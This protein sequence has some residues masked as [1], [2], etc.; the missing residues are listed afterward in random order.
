ME[1]D[2]LVNKRKS[3]VDSS[4]DNNF[5]FDS[6]LAGIYTD[7]SH[8]IYEILQNAEDAK[9]TEVSF[10]L[11]RDRFDIIHNGV[12]F[13][14][15]DVDGLTG[16]G[17][18]SKTN[19]LNKIGKFGVG[20]K[21]VFA[22]TKNPIIHSGKYHFQVNDFVVPE[23]INMNFIDK[24]IIS[25]P[26]NHPKR[27]SDDLYLLIS[28]KLQ[29]IDPLTLLFLTNIKKI[30]WT[31]QEK[32]GSYSKISENIHK[33][34]NVSRITITSNIREQISISK[35][36]VL[37]RPV[38]LDNNK[39]FVEL[40]YKLSQDTKGKEHI[41]KTP[42][43]KL[44]VFFP[45]S[46]V[47]F[48][49]FI[50]QGPYKTIPN[51]EDIP[52]NDLQ[53][54]LLINETAKL[55][56]ESMLI[57]KKLNLFSISFIELLPIDTTHLNEYIYKKIF[58]T[59]KKEFN[60]SEKYIPI[61][62][63]SFAY[64]SET[65]LGRGK[66]LINLLDTDD[67]QYIY[68]KSHWINSNITIDNTRELRNYF[69]NQLEINEVDFRDFAIQI[70]RKYIYQKT[71]A[72]LLKFYR[73][74]LKQRTLWYNS[75][76][77]NSSIL[78]NKP[79][80]RLTDNSLIAPFNEKNQVQVFFPSKTYA[81]TT[82]KCNI[83][84]HIFVNDQQS[85]DFFHRLGVTMP[86]LLVNI[87]NSVL[88]KYTNSN[89]G[90][91]VDD[92]INDL[93]YIFSC[94]KQMDQ[95]KRKALQEETS[96]F[97]LIHSLRYP[98]KITQFYRASGTYL[99]TSQ[100]IEYF[101]GLTKVLFVSDVIYNNFS[102][103]ASELNEFLIFLG[104]NKLPKLVK[105]DVILT[106]KQK[107]ELRNTKM[108]KDSQSFEYQLEGLSNFFK[109]LTIKRSYLLWDLLLKILADFKHLD[110]TK[111]FFG[112]YSWFYRKKRY[113]SF[114]SKLLKQ[115][116]NTPWL[117]NKNNEF[118]KSTK[119]EIEDLNDA[120]NLS[121]KY[122]NILIK[123]LNFQLDEIRSFE[124]KHHCKVLSSEELSEYNEFLIWKQHHKLE[125]DIIDNINL[126]ITSPDQLESNAIII[127]PDKIKL[128][129]LKNQK[130][131][132]EKSNYIEKKSNKIERNLPQNH[133]D[134]KFIGDWGEQY[135]NKYLTNKYMH[136][137]SIS[138]I[139]QNT[140]GSKGSGYDFT[141]L[142]NSEEIEYI[143]VKS[144]IDSRPQLFLTGTQW[145][146]SKKLYENNEGDKFKIYIVEN[147]L[148]DD[149]II[150]II[151]NPYKLWCESKLFAH[152]VQ[153]RL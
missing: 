145:L 33:L 110:K 7:P 99:N 89:P 2:K 135:V 14:Y 50:I 10:K 71:D 126:N 16:I 58:N 81:N 56:A 114:E 111:I 115:L 127:K 86:D 74:L 85:Y 34:I 149:A 146:F 6:I 103:T 38:V 102:G 47:T 147:A 67:L 144:K 53:N 152:P 41:V 131:V 142:S 12:N 44:N 107:K 17:I 54:Q 136:N 39:L 42:N 70:D 65:I 78:G 112:E 26:F 76:N 93:N 4:R 23:I 24:T 25:L 84:K 122:S 22:V 18:S 132:N 151:E 87:K 75:G 27:S 128:K 138:V 153:I 119:S 63:G 129:N 83:I 137:K 8:F 29:Y 9:A 21:S 1:F 46:K 96:K 125:E 91:S 3:W 113:T 101:K 124:Q 15:D 73:C 11:Y 59:V 30:Y 108:T 5:D 82:S 98:S 52:L 80:I 95:I 104:C 48:L 77:L 94:Y 45:T 97:Y 31:T 62:K 100:L 120:Y 43:S 72:W 28:Y 148:S 57:V 35:Y 55:V 20:F 32:T 143:E 117:V 121:H 90:I 61:E 66:D 139:W 118:V 68:G 106:Y 123:V 92:Y 105:V 49:N 141:I 109:E 36:L 19:D 140:N 79:I 13:N 51:R 116:L 134:L 37:K 60:S 69:I 150:K 133:I 40:A 88:P 64:P 130:P